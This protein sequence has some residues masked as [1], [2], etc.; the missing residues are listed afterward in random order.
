[1]TTTFGSKP[2]LVGVLNEESMRRHKRCLEGGNPTRHLPTRRS[3]RLIY[4]ETTSLRLRAKRSGWV[5]SLAQTYLS[6][7]K[8]GAAKSEYF[9]FLAA[10][11]FQTSGLA[12]APIA[13]FL[14]PEN[15]KSGIADRHSFRI[16]A[17]GRGGPGLR[18]S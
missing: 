15:R 11:G 12:R 17:A 13:D 7:V 8:Q 3:I 16:L 10:P 4:W 9:A 2:E 6:P 14:D 18:I 5:G 1:V